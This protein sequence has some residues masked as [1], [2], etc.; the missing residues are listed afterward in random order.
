MILYYLLLWLNAFLLN[1]AHW[2]IYQN[3]VKW[4]SGDI[5]S[6]V[7]RVFCSAI[8]SG[9]HKKNDLHIAGPLRAESTVEHWIPLAKGSAMWQVSPCHDIVFCMCCSCISRACIFVCVGTVNHHLNSLQIAANIV[10]DNDILVLRMKQSYDFK[11][12]G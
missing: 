10:N 2:H 5:G 7:S 9:C 1:L 12:M 4:A 8:C 6:P 11:Q 3:D